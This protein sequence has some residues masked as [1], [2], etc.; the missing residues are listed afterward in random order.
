MR[1]SLLLSLAVLLVVPAAA[2][3]ETINESYRVP[4]VGG[5]PVY[6]EV[7]RQAGVRSPVILT[8]SPYNVLGEGQETQ[9][10]YGERYVPRGYARAVA[11]VIGTRNSS[12]CWDYGG[13]AEQPYQTAPLAADVRIADA[14]RLRRP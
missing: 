1:R 11:D 14:T 8:Y 13:A 4:T 2:R 9:D 10:K 5:A 12:G 3:A 6:V 7:T